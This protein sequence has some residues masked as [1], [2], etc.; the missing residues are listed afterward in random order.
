MGLFS[1]IFGG[2]KSNPKMV[3]GRNPG[4]G[5]IEANKFNRAKGGFAGGYGAWT[6]KNIIDAHC[7]VDDIVETFGLN[8]EG[9][10]YCECWE[11]AYGKQY[12]I[13]EMIYKEWVDYYLGVISSLTA[14]MNMCL[15]QAEELE[16]EAQDLQE[17]AE[18]LRD[19][20]AWSEDPE[21]RADLL[22]EAEILEQE[23]RLLLEQATQLRLTATNLQ[24]Q[25]DV[26]YSA[27]DM[28]TIEQFVNYD[29]VEKNA[30][31]S[32]IDFAKTWINGD[33]WIP[34]EV[35]SWAYYEISSHNK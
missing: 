32:A 14:E 6:F 17:Q 35:L 4:K 15:E 21:E 11:E 9:C 31:S 24:M 30:Y 16:Q 25:I 8:K 10:Q 22:A 2:G 29:E 28:L 33:T 12:N 26:N 7:T 18:D 1:N 23:A 20:A 27:I 13:A 5:W 3:S 19:D 34:E